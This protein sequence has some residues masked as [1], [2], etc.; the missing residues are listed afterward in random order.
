MAQGKNK[1]QIMARTVIFSVCLTIVAG[2]S[3]SLMSNPTVI[4]PPITQHMFLRCG[5]NDDNFVQSGDLVGRSVPAGSTPEKRSYTSER[6]K[7]VTGITLSRNDVVIATVNAYFPA[8]M[9]QGVDLGDV[10]VT[11]DVSQTTGELGYL[12]LAWTFPTNDATGHYE[13]D[14]R[15]ITENRHMVIYNTSLDIQ[16][17]A[18]SMQDMLEE[19]TKLKMN[20][21]TQTTKVETQQT[22]ITSLQNT[23][24]TLRDDVATLRHVEQGVVDCQGTNSHWFD[25]RVAHPSG[26]HGYYDKTRQVTT[27]FNTSYRSPPV[28]FLS[29]SYRWISKDNDV[30]Y[31]T[32]LMEVTRDS[33]TLLC[34]GD[35][36]TDHHLMDMEVDWLSVAV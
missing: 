26:A 25:G 30:E 6:V 7:H 5:L 8:A 9:E 23:V 28:V 22:S 2:S 27:S 29:T 35:N 32:K 1:R 36:N 14:V 24:A 15:G 4:K 3:I 19:I 31:G 34:G 33:F 21:A 16:A 11:G 17:E 12:Q 10:N 20:L 18:V 13:C